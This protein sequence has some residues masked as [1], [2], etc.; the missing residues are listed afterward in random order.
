MRPLRF[1]SLLLIGILTLL[2]FIGEPVYSQDTIYQYFDDGGIATS[3]SLIKIGFDPVNGEVP[4]IFEHRL[5]R[6]I[7]VEWG[8]G[9]VSLA[10]QSKRYEDIEG[11]TGMG[12]NVW[13]NLRVYL[14]GYYERFYM[15]FQPRFNYLDG[16][17]YMDIVFFN[18]GYQRPLSGRLIFDINAGLGVRSYKEDDTVINTV[19]YDNGRGSAFFIPVQFKLGY[20]F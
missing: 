16:K 17:S 19:V 12:F 14:K 18:A 20:A 15:G 6:H 8:T 5:T 4:V 11:I 7:S 9:L 2:G 13:A 3:Y 1:F 10:R